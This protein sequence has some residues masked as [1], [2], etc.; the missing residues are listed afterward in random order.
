MASSVPEQAQERSG[1]FHSPTLPE[2]T[3][4]SLFEPIALDVRTF[5]RRALRN[6]LKEAAGF[7]FPKAT[8]EQALINLC[9]ILDGGSG[10]HLEAEW[11]RVW[12][13]EWPW[14]NDALAAYWAGDC[15]HVAIPRVDPDR[16]AERVRQLEKAVDDVAGVMN[17]VRAELADMRIAREREKG[18]SR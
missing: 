17:D 15:G 10:R 8:V 2:I 12:A 7:A 4:A 13:R 9:R 3:Q 18:R 11:M 16:E 6:H 5:C 14:F 1:E